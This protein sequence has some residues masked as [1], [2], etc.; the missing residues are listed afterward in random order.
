MSPLRRLPGSLTAFTQ[1]Q[2][3]SRAC[4]HPHIDTT[5]RMLKVNDHHRGKASVTQHVALLMEGP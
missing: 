5:A 1:E 4:V 3:R 2:I